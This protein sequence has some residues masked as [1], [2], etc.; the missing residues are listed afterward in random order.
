[1]AIIRKIGLLSYVQLLAITLAG[2]I[3]WAEWDYNY[4]AFA[5]SIPLEEQEKME[6][7]IDTNY[8]VGTG[9]LI[10]VQA[11]QNYHDIGNRPL[12]SP[13]RARPVPKKKVLIQAAVVKEPMDYSLKLNGVSISDKVKT[14]LVWHATERKFYTVERGDTV[15]NWKVKEIKPES[16]VLNQNGEKMELLLRDKVDKLK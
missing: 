2:W 4:L 8:K 12:F 14:A 11:L 9:K 7:G 6:K 5:N 10:T 3:V 16:V 15:K 13:T 1:M